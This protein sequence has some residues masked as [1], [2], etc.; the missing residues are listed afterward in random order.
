MKEDISDILEFQIVDKIDNTVKVVY[1]SAVENNAQ[2]IRLCNA[3][4]LRLFGQLWFLDDSEYFDVITYNED[5]SLLVAPS[6]EGVEAF[7]G[8]TLKL[9]KPYYLRG[10][11]RAVNFEWNKLSEIEGFKL[12]LVWLVNPTPEKFFTDPPIERNSDLRILLLCYANFADDW[13]KEHREKNVIPLMNLA[14]EI[15]KAVNLNQLYFNRVLDYDTKDF[16]KFG[17]EDNSGII[18]NIIDAN[19][20]GV[21]LRISLEVLKQNCNC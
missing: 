6:N 18:K 7:K 9:E 14:D 8:Q 15:V 3:K 11:A 5:G 13:T 19:L 1:A 12:P 2:T 20:S 16:A 10:T 21:E 17:T 4:Y